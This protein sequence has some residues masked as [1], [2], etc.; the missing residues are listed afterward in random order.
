MIE[1]NKP[2]L[3]ERLMHSL[4]LLACP[5]EV[6]LGSFPSFVHVPDELALDFD[7]FR[8]AF[9]GNFRTEITAEQLYCLDLIDECLSR[10]SKDCYSHE[11]VTEAPEWQNARQ[12]AARALKAFGWP[13][14]EPPRR[15]YEFVPRN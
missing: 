9:V 4:Q 11:A 7:N 5:P 2:W 13:P 8:T 15:D 12:L 1:V 10:M 14:G 6:Q 3:L